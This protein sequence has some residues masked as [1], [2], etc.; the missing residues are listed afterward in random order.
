MADKHKSIFKVVLDSVSKL[1]WLKAIR[2]PT[3]KNMKPGKGF[4]QPATNSCADELQYLSHDEFKKLMVLIFKQRGYT[5]KVKTSQI[6]ED[7]DLILQ[8]NN[9]N[10]FVKFN[11]WQEA[12]LDVNEI[13]QLYVAM[14]EE[15]ISHGIIITSGEFTSEA[16][17]LSLGKAILLINGID[18][19]LMIEALQSSDILNE[20]EDE[21]EAKDEMPE[22]DPLCPICSC[23]MIKRTARKGKNAGNTFWGCSTYPNCRGVVSE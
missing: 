21:P 13:A 12:L 19:S 3:H 5:V 11:R 22:L 18:L 16:L 2:P 20:E 14:K 10:T 17:D 7:I 4:N 8:V 1:T 6:H 9:E 23:K 15:N